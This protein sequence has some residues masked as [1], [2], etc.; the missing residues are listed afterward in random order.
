MC[1]K[2]ENAFKNIYHIVEEKQPSEKGGT[3]A[4]RSLF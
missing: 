3:S 4:P 1:R 2:N